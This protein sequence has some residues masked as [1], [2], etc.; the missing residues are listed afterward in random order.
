MIN[1]HR[2]MRLLLPFLTAVVL[3]AVDNTRLELEPARSAPAK[4]KH[5]VLLS[6]DEEYRSEEALPMLAK[7]L[8]QRHGFKTTVLF[9][10]DADGTINPTQVQSLPGADALDTADVIIMSLRFRAWPDEAMKHFD[11]AHRRGVPIIALRTSTHA[12]NFPA[13]S[14]WSNY[15]W[16][17][18]TT[19]PGGF[20]RQV[21]GETWVAHWGKHKVEATRG[22]LEPAAT[23]DA[24]FNSVTDLFGTTDVY[25]A[26]PPADAK[27]LARGLVLQGMRPTDAPATYRK[28]TAAKIE[29]AVNA[30]AMP[31]VW[32]RNYL[33]S[34]GASAKIF[35]TTLGAATDFE[36]ESLRRLIV[37]A[38]YWAAELA[39]P[40]KAD[41]TPFDNYAPR[42]YGFAGYRTGLTPADHALGKILPAGG[43]VP[44]A[45]PPGTPNAINT[46]ITLNLGAR[47]AFIGNGLADRMQHAG[48]LE[49][50]IHA[51]YPKHEL[52]FRNLAV[53]GDEIVARARSKDFGTPDEW[54]SRTGTDVIFAFFG[55]NESFAGPAGL[56]KFKAD[57]AAFLSDTRSKN[58]GTHGVP[59][60]VLFSP[61]ANE[62]LS[63]RNYAIPADNNRNLALYAAAMAEVARDRAGVTFIDLFAPSQKLYA[64]AAAQGRALTFNGLHLTAAGDAAL[65]PVI[66][67]TLFGESAPV[68]NFTAL[69]TAVTAKN[70]EWHARYRTMDGFNVYGDRSKLAYESAKDKPKLTNNQIMQE[71][72]AQRDVLTA[73]RDRQLWALAR[74]ETTPP[75][76][77]PLPPVTPFGTNKPG[78]NPD[79][80]YDFLSADEALTKMTLAPGV[81]VNVFASEKEFPELANAVQMAWDPQGRLWVSVWPNYP[82]R[83]PT[84]TLGDS[85]IILEDTDHDGR[86]DKC[87]HFLDN[88]NCPTGFQFYKDG[89]LV[90]Q[91]PD[92]WFARDTDGDGKA[93]TK[94]RVLMGLDSADSHHTANSFVY[95]PGGAILLSDGVFHRS[96][97]ET[98]LG[99]VRNIDGAIYRFEPRTGKFETYASYNFMNP[100]GRAFDYWGNDFITDATGNHTYFGAAISGKIDYP[101]KHPKLKTIWDRP[102]RPSAGSSI[103]TSTHFPPEYW[104]NYLNPNVIGFQGIYRLKLVDDGAG[105]KGERQPDLM[106]STDR[107][108][109]PIDTSVGPDGAI[110]VIDWCTPLI[111]HLQ[112]HLRDSNR[113]HS[114]GRIYRLTYEGRPLATPPA[115]AGQP[116]PALLKLLERPENQIRNLAKIELG[117]HDTAKVIAAAKVWLAALDPTTPDYAHHLTEALWLH[118]W[119]NVVDEDLLQRVLNSPNAD[120]RAAAV[121]VLGYW[122]DRLPTALTLL[123]SK[124]TDENARVRLHAV[125]A[126]SFFSETG[127]T[128]IALAATKLPI[129]YYLDYTIGETL[130]QLRP[131]WAK[132]ISEGTAIAGGDPAS[133][134]Y[135]LRTLAVAELL[136]L[137]RTVDVQENILGRK[138]INDT[139]RAEALAAVAAARQVDRV[140]LLLTTIDSPA[141]IDVKSVG[142][143]L[144]AQPAADL[145]AQRPAIHKLALTDNAEGRSFAWAALAIADG[146]LTALWTEALKSPLTEASFLGGLSLIPD[147][148]LRA[149]AYEIVMPILATKVAD[150]P[151][152]PATVAA[153]QREAIRTAVSTRREPTAV[154]N[155]LA[156]LIARGDQIPAAAQGLRVLPRASWPADSAAATA[157]ILVAWAANTH[158][159]ERTE[160]D[161]FGHLRRDYSETVQVADDLLGTLPAAEAETLRAT[162]A[163]LR[164]AVFTVTTVPEEMRF[165][166]ARLVVEAGKPFEIIFENIDGLPH[167]LVVVKPGTRERVG[168]AAMTL[169]PEQLDWNGRAYVPNSSDVIAAT[170]ILETDQ[171][172]TLKI[173]E[174]TSEGIYEFVCTFPGHWAMMYGQLVVTKNVSA[175]LKDNPLPPK[176][177]LVTT[178]ELCDPRINQALASTSGN[179]RLA[180]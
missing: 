65:A 57:L 163:G 160:R 90:M 112:S 22:V 174:L 129:D 165:D 127:A 98:A 67:K 105:I 83:T 159:S 78:P 93:D 139:V 149:T 121:R 77:I 47:I 150:L 72:M 87:I 58:Y 24:L 115:I 138:G 107:D 2:S 60:I 3:G 30:P 61:I 172:A 35:T 16:N 23:T 143:L 117:R 79:G 144:L 175:Y 101:K 81:K 140:A 20:G 53:T 157:R 89:L 10:L 9:A 39:V 56:T 147:A 25:E 80:T 134:R 142:R 32:T 86:A 171:L 167:N 69:Q 156:D 123:Q 75:E 44:S 169:L 116:I 13:G 118:Q 148:A 41:V 55:F 62:N 102:S 126:A 152:P 95:E 131:L 82:E 164:V 84:S 18:K 4:G 17:N 21:L 109:R 48:A 113:D 132:S 161:I 136:K 99:P 162:L 52:V 180:P 153:I 97:I 122:R 31:I 166:T 133:F 26:A 154:F 137:P 51:K 15:T 125:R 106:S 114:H 155:A 108:F 177:P 40:A 50:L 37:N 46:P 12:F 145:R 170:K 45:P 168:L 179:S 11:A 94:E 29:Q 130:R 92:L 7:I 176:Q 76:V 128:E 70:Q 111:G 103:I 146:S 91:A 49:T 28:T 68:G 59:H 100:H 96:Q 173:S 124:A 19:H 120:A 5:V 85:I 38:T 14:P 135:L 63:D 158:P 71:E 36:Q 1:L 178:I 151:G 34:S 43:T 141:E 8:S 54:L 66:F 110:Y 104:G 119:H 42:P 27:I 74:G 33:T 6:G 88:L 64:E 73:N